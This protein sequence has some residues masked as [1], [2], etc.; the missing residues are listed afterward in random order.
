MLVTGR[1]YMLMMGLFSPVMML[2]NYFQ[3]RKQGKMSYRQQLADYKD[4]KRRIEADAAQAVVDERLARR[5]DAPDPAMVLLVANG[6]R[7]RLWERRTTDPDYLAVRVVGDLESEVTVDDPEQLEHRRKTIRTAYDVPVTIPLAERGVVG[8]AGRDDLPRRVA[9]WAV[10]QLA[11][12]QSPRDTL[13]YVLTD[14]DGAPAWDWL[15]WLPHA[16]PSFGQDTVTTVGIDAETCARTGSPSCSRPCRQAAQERA[17]APGDRRSDPA[18]S[19]STAPAAPAAPGVVALLKEGPPLG[20]YSICLDAD[21]RLLP[22]EADRGRVV[23]DRSGLTAPPAADHRRRRRDAG[24]RRAAVA[25]AGRPG[26][27]AAPRHLRW[28]R[29]LGSCPRRAGSPRSMQLEPSAAQTI[30]AALGGAAALHRGAS[31][32]SPSTVPSPSTC[33]ATARTGW[34][35][36]PPAPAS[37]S[38]CS[39]WWPPSRS[40]TGRTR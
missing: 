38:C 13:V 5:L 28:R 14:P 32:G 33:A 4:K 6:P 21:E 22:E 19:S 16:R 26:A 20:I 12:L 30:M 2:G 11:V 23:D 25:A 27:G 34:S 35:P 29:R 9:S 15:R 17:P 36:A 8:I 24:P 37:P 40:P 10:A 31:S 1:L 39:R 7:A 3:N 18:S